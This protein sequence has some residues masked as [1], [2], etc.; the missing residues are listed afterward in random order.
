MTIKPLKLRQKGETDDQLR[1]R[2]ASALSQ[3]MTEASITP[4]PIKKP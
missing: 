2:I 1:L 4:P 3:L